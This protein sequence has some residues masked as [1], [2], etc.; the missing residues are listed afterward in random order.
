MSGKTLA[1]EAVKEQFCT[2]DKQ[3][4]LEKILELLDLA[5][6]RELRFIYI[7]LKNMIQKEG[8]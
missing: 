6:E 2:E 4:A 3:E 1:L 8:A 5:E 7:V